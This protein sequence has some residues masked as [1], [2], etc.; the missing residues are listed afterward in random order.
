VSIEP[1]VGVP[2]CLVIESDVGALEVISKD[3]TIGPDRMVDQAIYQDV[4]FSSTKVELG[5]KNK[6][7]NQ[8]YTVP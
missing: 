1:V 6:A 5:I 2:G 8:V 7:L 3:V 4:S